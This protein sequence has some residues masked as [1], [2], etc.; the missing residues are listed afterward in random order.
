MGSWQFAS[1]AYLKGQEGPLLQFGYNANVYPENPNAN[2]VPAAV[3]PNRKGAVGVFSGNSAVGELGSARYRPPDPRLA[4]S[5]GFNAS[6][7]A[8]PYITGSIFNEEVLC[9]SYNIS[10]PIPG[11]TAQHTIPRCGVGCRPEASM[12][13]MFVDPNRNPVELATPNPPTGRSERRRAAAGTRRSPAGFS[14]PVD[15]ATP[16]EASYIYLTPRKNCP[17]GS[18]P[19]PVRYRHRITSRMETLRGVSSQ[20]NM[21]CRGASEIFYGFGGH[22]HSSPP[23][24]R[25]RR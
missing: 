17:R 9:K 20:S 19:R 1:I 7:V 5:A 2:A 25:Y 21:G 24:S 3:R 23:S 8:N 18:A 11:V 14:R 12:R 15:M 4:P 13:R 10:S 6:M 22:C 16:R